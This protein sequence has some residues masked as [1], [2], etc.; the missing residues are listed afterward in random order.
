MIVDRRTDRVDLFTRRHFGKW[1]EATR[2]RL[3]AL[4]L[5]Y[6][7]ANPTFWLREHANL[8]LEVTLSPA[9][10]LRIG[11]DDELLVGHDQYLVV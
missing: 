11:A 2:K 5:G 8:D 6:F 4:N 7:S 1:D 3:I 10:R 9:N